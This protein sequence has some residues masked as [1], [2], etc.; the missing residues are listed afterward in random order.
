MT[1]ST[2]PCTDFTQ[3]SFPLKPP[4]A[5][6][7]TA[8]IGLV[9]R[10][11]RAAVADCYNALGAGT[12][13]MARTRSAVERA[14][15]LLAE[16]FGCDGTDI[17][18]TSSTGEAINAVARAVPWQ[19]GDE[20]LVLEDEFPTTLLPWSRI[21]GVRLVT[22]APGPDDDRLGALLAAIGP[23]T[24][25]VSVSHVNSSTGTLVDLVTLGEA[26]ARGGALLLCDG[27]Q[28]AG[29]LPVDLTGVDF[30]VATG[31]KWMLAGFGI[32]FVI[33][34]ASVRD[35]LTPTLLGHGNVPPSHQLTVGTSN[36]A[37]IHALG[38]AADLRRRIGREAIMQRAGALA[39]RIREEGTALGLRPVTRD[40]A[41]GTIISFA[42]PTPTVSAAAV[43]QLRRSDVIVA[44]RGGTIR[45][46]PHF[47]TRD[48]EVDAL[49]TALSHSD[50]TST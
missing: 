45:V 37:G 11:V 28:S 17:T 30:F 9:P 21:P 39:R 5:Y 49:L 44:D 19:P 43:E 1:P 24:R 35:T 23:R 18:F 10:E 41:H 22:V 8:S 16:E 34:K 48:S 13:G 27:A 38:A 12:Q 26:C 33:T 32:A 14:R 3:T 47:Y 15:T 40:N 7:D 25:L 6:L 2:D 20:V 42:P 4:V 36:L 31:Y 46:S 29:A 50:I